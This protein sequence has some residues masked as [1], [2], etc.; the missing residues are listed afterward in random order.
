[1]SMLSRLIAGDTLDFVD[2][3]PQYP[4]TDGWTLRY[5]LTPTFTVPAQTPI[6]I[7]AVV[8]QVTD[9][10]VQAAPAATVN[11]VPG[12]Y[13]W[14]RWVERVGAR[15]SLGSG[16]LTVEPNIA[17]LPA[18]HDGR[19]LAQRTLDDLLAA[20]SQWAATSGRIRSY[21]IAGR[22]ME[23]R[24]AA[25]LEAEIAFWRRQLAEETQAANLAAGLAPK[26]RILTRFMR[27]R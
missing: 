1:M 15:Q 5:R 23:F 18:G 9:Y 25:E 7:T 16:R 8:H 21:S 2:Q 6:E 22:T 12:S 3:V 10:R 26:N 27:P 14:T 4:A 19:S 24:E 17:T 11:W 20:R 13:T